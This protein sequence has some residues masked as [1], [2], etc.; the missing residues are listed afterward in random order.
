MTEKQIPSREE[1][2]RTKEQQQGA[3]PGARVSKPAL[4]SVA[5]EAVFSPQEAFEAFTMPQFDINNTYILS[6]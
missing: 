5:V 4:N 1:K 6:D 3:K 2:K